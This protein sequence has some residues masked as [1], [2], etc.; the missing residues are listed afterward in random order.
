MPAAELVVNRVHLD[1]LGE[2]SVDEV[3]DLLAGELGAELAGRVARNLADFDVLA[4]RD[5]ATVASLSRLLGAGEPTL[6]PRLDREVQDLL[7]LAE[8]AEHLLA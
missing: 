5:R 6:V 2:R 7:G 8:I 1:D 3:G 4:R